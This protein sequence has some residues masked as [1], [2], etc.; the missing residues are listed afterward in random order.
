MKKAEEDFAAAQA[1]ARQRKNP[2][3]NVVCFHAQQCVEKYLK[4]FLV[5]HRHPFSKTH[6]LIELLELSFATATGS[7]PLLQ[8]LEAD[9]RL[10]N[11]YSVATRYPTATEVTVDD[12]REAKLAL[13]R[14][15]RAVRGLLG[16]K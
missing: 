15:R 5:Y 14:V 8:K 10:L 11:L 2:L 13:R 6:D 16:I 3:P 12:A 9:L 4:A 1:L 7:V